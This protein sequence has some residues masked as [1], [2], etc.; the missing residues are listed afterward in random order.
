MKLRLWSRAD[1][2]SESKEERDGSPAVGVEKLLHKSYCNFE[3]I[4]AQS[5]VAEAVPSS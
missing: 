4:V 5:K 1:C 3:H 2:G